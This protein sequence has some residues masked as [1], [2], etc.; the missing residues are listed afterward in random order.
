VRAH[1]AARQAEAVALPVASLAQPPCRLLQRTCTCGGAPGANGE[2]AACRERRLRRSAAGATRSVAAPGIVPD[3]LSSGGRPLDAVT[4]VFMERRFG[5]DFAAV[6][7]HTDVRAS[8]SARAVDAAAYTVGSDIAFAPGRYRPETRE[9]R[10]LLAHELSHVLQQRG[11]PRSGPLLVGREDTAHEHEAE[12]AARALGG[13]SRSSRA[14]PVRAVQ[15]QADEP[16]PFGEVERD[17]EE[18]EEKEEERDPSEAHDGDSRV[19]ATPEAEEED[20]AAASTGEAAPELALAGAEEAEPMKGGGAGKGKAKTPAPNKPSPLARTIVKI[21]VDQAA[22]TMTL[23]W[24][25]GTKEGPRRVSTGRG[26]PNTKDDPCKTQTEK[27]CTPNDTFT[28]E[29]LGNANTKNEHGDRMSWYVGFLDRR[30]I[31]IHD[32]QPVPGT[33]ASHGCVRVGDRPADDAFA[34]MINKNVVVGKTV[35]EVSGKAPTKPWTKPVPKKPP[36]KKPAP[37][38][39]R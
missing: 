4:R 35:V 3:V 16:E 21:K 8:Q 6:R 11:A 12:A 1:A 15:R 18:E 25:D 10:H 14:L 30:G 39:T 9:G 23:T 38:K 27:N 22:Q 13:G 17:E 36:A 33:P 31:G 28:V 2:C 5:H 7:V 34:K 20:A 24:S 29:S 19:H 32:S 37:K 26:L